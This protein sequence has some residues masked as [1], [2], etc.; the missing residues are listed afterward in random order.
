MYGTDR[1]LRLDGSTKADERGTM[2]EDF[3]APD[4][5]YFLFMLSTRAGGLGLNLQTADTVIMFDSD[6]NPQADLQAEDRAHR[7]GQKKEVLVLV[8]VTAGTIEEAILD[9]AKQKREIDAKVIQAGMFNDNSTHEQRQAVLKA[10]MARGAG[11]VVDSVHDEGEVN[12]MLA[13]S[14][15]EFGLFCEMDEGRDRTR[16]RLMGEGEVPAWVVAEPEKEEEESSEGGETGGRRLRKR[17][18]AQRESDHVSEA[19]LNRCEA[20][21]SYFWALLL[22]LLLPISP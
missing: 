10:I 13:R 21:C 11:D 17:Q 22:L 16:P 19:E 9:K 7:I 4:S 12:E 2:L 6:W 1:H 3:N 5:D 8:L 14:P 18:R 15:E 20:A